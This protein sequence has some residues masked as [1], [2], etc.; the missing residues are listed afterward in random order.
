MPAKQTLLNLQTSS[1]RYAEFSQFIARFLDDVEKENLD[2]KKEEILSN[3]LGQLKTNL[4]AYQ[5]SLGQVRVSEKSSTITEA[6][7]LRDED[8]QALREAIKPY[9]N[10]RRENEKAAY[11]TLDL[12]FDQYKKATKVSYEEESALLNSLLEK[13]RKAE[14]QSAIETLGIGRFMNNLTE[15]QAAFE[16]VFSDRSQENL[17]KVSFDT[18]QLRKDLAVPYQQLSDYVA[19][20]AQLKE[21][22]IYQ[23]TLSVLN[24]S[25]KYYAD[26]LAR[27]KGKDKK[28]AK[29][30]ETETE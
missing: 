17:A 6:D 20:L 21:D 11:K 12:L 15:S 19:I 25:R 8:F 9:R 24:N 23:K 7:Q 27:R 1:L 2:V 26:V 3:L 18:K 16:K 29:K 4:P 28:E 13:L 5:A 10:S 22:A 30:V 14:Y